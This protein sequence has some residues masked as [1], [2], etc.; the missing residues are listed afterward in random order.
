MKHQQISH[1][2]Q[3]F[4][5]EI[6]VNFTIA[7][8]SSTQGFSMQGCKPQLRKRIQLP[9]SPEWYLNVVVDYTYRR[10]EFK[11]TG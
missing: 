6:K 7:F 8:S 11:H 2:L 10:C 3:V 5:E 9:S 4:N 1:C